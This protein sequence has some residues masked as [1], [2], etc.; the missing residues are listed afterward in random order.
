MA[1]KKQTITI[2]GAGSAGCFMAILLAKRGYHVQIFERFSREEIITSYTNRSFN[3]TFYGY[4]VEALQEAGLWDEVKPHF[5]TLRGSITQVTK[6]AKPVF[7]PFNLDN[8]SYYTIQ[9]A[10]LLEILIAQAEKDSRITFNFETS[11]LS[12]DRNNKTM[13]IQRKNT[14]TVKTIN[15]AVVIGADGVNS[16]VRPFLQQGQQTQHNQEYEKWSYK[17]IFLTKQM[18]K[19]I[20][21]ANDTQYTWTRKNASLIAFPN[22]DDSFTAMLIVPKDS[23]HGFANLISKEQINTFI[24]EQFPQLRP[25]VPVFINALKHNPEGNFVTVTTDSWFYK[26]FLVL[27]GD[28]AHGCLPFYGIGTSVAFGDCLT[29]INKIDQF[30]N[31]WEKVFPAYQLERKKHT[32]VIADLAK[33]SFVGFRRYKKADFIAVYDRIESLLHTLLPKIFTPPL[34]YLVANN[35]NAAAE[36][37]QKHKKQRKMANMFGLFLIVKGITGFLALQESLTNRG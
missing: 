18:V 37:F 17:Q 32:D 22:G 6:R 2:I 12:I 7:V 8:M 5:L 1:S 30:D 14:S 13:H 29:L 28:A 4:A 23:V 35:P 20:A 11:L 27:I 16:L 15:C 10:K 25:F 21:L 33:K 24:T 3:L 26:D 19:K 31:N 9:R 34:F 36:Y